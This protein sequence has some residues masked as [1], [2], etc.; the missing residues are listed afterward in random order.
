MVGAVSPNFAGTF[1]MN[2]MKPPLKWQ[3]LTSLAGC[4]DVSAE[5]EIVICRAPLEGKV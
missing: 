4:E 2:G 3:V 5:S 1:A